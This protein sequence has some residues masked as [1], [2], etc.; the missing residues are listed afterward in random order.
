MHVR[1]WRT[2]YVWAGSAVLSVIC[3]LA[4]VFTGSLWTAILVHDLND[5]GFLTL[6]G[7]R[8]VF[9]ARSGSAS[10]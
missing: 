3:S 7:R 10:A 6:V 4:V 1:T 9:S 8:D 2:P 5:F